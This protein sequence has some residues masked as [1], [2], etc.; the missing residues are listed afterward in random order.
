MEGI[1]KTPSQKLLIA[2]ALPSGKLH[3]Y[4]CVQVL[5]I[6]EVLLQEET[7]AVL[8]PEAESDSLQTVHT[9]GCSSRYGEKEYTSVQK[10][11][12]SL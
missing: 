10:A 2:A 9:Q 6:F 5:L 11:K 8:P 7:W 12:E 3:F 1:F 4:P